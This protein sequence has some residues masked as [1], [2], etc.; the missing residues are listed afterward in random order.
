ML[1]LDVIEQSHSPFASP[2]AIV[3]KPD[4]SNRSCVYFR[5]LNKI[6]SFDAE[7]IPDQDEIF[8]KIGKSKYFSKV[9]LK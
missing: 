7:P 8:T 6:T 4:G 2:I 5:R 3:K 9:D 1:S